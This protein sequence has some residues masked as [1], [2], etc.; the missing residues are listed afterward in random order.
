MSWEFYGV[1]QGLGNHK[2]NWDTLNS[3][4]C[5]SNPFFDSDFI[6]NLLKHFSEGNE[7]LCV[8]TSQGGVDGM[9][10]VK[11]EPW[12]RWTL[13]SPAQAQIDPLLLKDTKLLVDLLKALPGF[14]RSLVCLSQ[15]PLYNPIA[16]TIS[17]LS[18]IT[19]DHAQTISVE[20]N[21]SFDEYWSERPKNLRK[22]IRNRLH[23]LDG[24]DLSTRFVLRE[25]PDEMVDAIARY[26]SLESKGWKELAGTA[27]H[28]E[29]SQGSFY[30]GVMT[31]FAKRGR[32]LVYELYFGDTLAASRI[33]IASHDML[34]ILKTSYDEDF[35]VYAPGRL[36]LYMLLH[37]EFNRRRFKNIEFYT[38][39]N[40]DQLAW[41]THER[42][43]THVKLFR[44]QALKSAYLWTR[45][46]RDLLGLKHIHH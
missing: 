24:V 17:G 41:A 8:H 39:A 29:D 40:I 22:N 3:A 45:R 6:D 15:D 21:S 36:L 27:V 9:L 32:A 10:I 2:A 23:R 28:L 4:L 37:H 31:D 46:L 19:K 14:A 7:K 18:L 38:N 5:N 30:C 13:F 12:G 26:A 33:C 34:V 35:S 44:N 1:E 42:M 20:I 11:P 25:N 43:I 16:S